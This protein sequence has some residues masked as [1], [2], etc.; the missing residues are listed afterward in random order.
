MEGSHSGLVH[1]LGKMAYR[2]VPR[3]RISPPPPKQ[4]SIALRYRLLFLGE[5]FERERGREESMFLEDG[6][7]RLLIGIFSATYILYPWNLN[8]LVLRKL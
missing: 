5:R 4:K 3:V 1:H 8:N 6:M 7:E 2:K